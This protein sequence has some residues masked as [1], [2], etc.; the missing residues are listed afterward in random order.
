MSLT[1]N[2]TAASD[3]G[4]VRGNN[5][6][7]AYAGPHLL[8]L[9]DGMG[10]H[11]AGEVASQ[12]M[13]EHL[14]HLDR[15]PGDA[16][17]LALLGA[18]ADDANAAI[19]DSVAHHPDQEGMGTTLTALMFNGSELGLIHVGD[20]RGY[21]LRDGALTQITV[22]DTFVQSLVEEGKLDPADVSSH[23]QKSLILKAYTGRPVEPG[24]SLLD[25]HV[26]DRY[27]LCSDGLSDPVT[28]ATIEETLSQGTPDVAAQRLIELALRSGGPD[29]V[30]VVVADVVEAGDSP[31]PHAPVAPVVAG[32]LAPPFES[33]PATSAGRAAALMRASAQREAEHSPAAAEDA[34]PEPEPRRRRSLW[35]WLVAVLLL[36]IA[37]VG[38]YAWLDSRATD[39]YY[40]AAGDNSDITIQQQ[41]GSVLRSHDRVGIQVAC[42]N[43]RN[44]L[45]IIGADEDRAGCHVFSVNDLPPAEQSALEN[46]GGGSYEDA[47]AVMNRLAERALPVCVDQ[48]SSNCRTVK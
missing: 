15:D 45:R 19:S 37:G 25:A 7:S 29:N 6:D 13:V 33:T 24:L 12:L 10:G 18:A 23:P 17:M 31:A 8:V 11:A 41:K 16:D 28:A 2:F 34:E 32:A 43:E 44:E 4:L 1:L 14:E 27:L 47:A 3:R 39:T 46:F 48:Q 35:P 26:G 42:I 20:S 36:A 30:T 22:D 9:A 5:E 40:V 21:R 38:G